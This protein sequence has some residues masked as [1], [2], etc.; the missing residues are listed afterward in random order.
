MVWLN[1]ERY[2][3]AMTVGVPSEFVVVENHLEAAG[4][5]QGEVVPIE[6][7]VWLC[8]SVISNGCCGMKAR[9]RNKSMQAL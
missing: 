8:L 9:C 4:I 3:E 7:I 6:G 1:E 2:L 5:A